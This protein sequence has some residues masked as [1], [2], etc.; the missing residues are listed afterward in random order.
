MTFTVMLKHEISPERIADL[1]ITAIE[2]GD[3]VTTAARGGWC[4]GI[5]LKGPLPDGNWYADPKLYAGKFTLEIIEVDDESTGHE[6]KH[7]V[8]RRAIEKGLA[9]M[10]KD[11]PKLFQW[12]VDDNVDA[13]CADIFLQCV[14]FGEEKYA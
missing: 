7:R 5:N 1:F 13:S 10:A 6:T 11:F 8:G 2:S 14:V 4:N 9:V 12:I 3:P